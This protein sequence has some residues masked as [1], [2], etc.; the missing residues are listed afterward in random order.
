MKL[1]GSQLPIRQPATNVHPAGPELERECAPL[2]PILP[3]QCVITGAHGLPNRHVLHCLGP[4]YGRDEPSDELLDWIAWVMDRSFRIPGT[5]VRFGLDPL[6]GILPFGGDA[7]AGEDGAARGAD[8]AGIALQH[9]IGIEPEP[10]RI[11]QPGDDGLTPR[12]RTVLDELTAVYGNL[13]TGGYAPGGVTSGH[14]D[15]S[16][17]YEGRA[18]DVMLRPHDDTEV[19]RRGWS[20]AQW[21]VAHA[22]RLGIA[23][24]IYDDR[25]WTARRSGEGWRAYQHPSG[26]A[27][28]ITLRHLDHVHIDVVAGDAP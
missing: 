18:I 26:D 19:N 6:M 10:G 22:Q 5:K 1:L 25:I 4:V 20:I 7:A 8:G 23:T 15:G 27:E 14:I 24:V 12:A 28:N 9:G 16:A 13:E 11:E 2:A 17:H 3:G 21:A